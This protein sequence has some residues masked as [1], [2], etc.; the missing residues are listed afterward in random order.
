MPITRSQSG[1]TK[2]KLA[3]IVFAIVLLSANLFAQ[4]KDPLDEYIDQ[5]KS[6]LVVRCLSVGAV[7]ILLRAKVDV[8]VIHVIKGPKMKEEI[9]VD[10]QYGMKIGEFYLLRI[11][12]EPESSGLIRADRRD[13]VIPLESEQEAEGLKA[14]LPRIAVLRSLNLR[15]DRLESEIRI[16]NY[17]LEEL[18]RVRK[19]N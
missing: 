19:G 12:D 11:A 7:N 10:S 17:E 3:L 15:I 13:S 9:I 1:G 8:Q 4:R 6:I 2:M 5:A 18:K 14:F 16:R